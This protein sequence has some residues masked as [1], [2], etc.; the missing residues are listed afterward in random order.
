MY[1]EC[2]MMCQTRC[3]QSLDNRI[4]VVMVVAV[5]YDAS[6]LRARRSTLR[7]RRLFFVLSV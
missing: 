6:H 1:R 2:V 3:G 5:V 4:P 7:R